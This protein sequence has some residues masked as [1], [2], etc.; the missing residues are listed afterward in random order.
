MFRIA[1]LLVKYDLISDI[2]GQGKLDN[3]DLYPQ[4]YHLK[5]I[6]TDHQKKTH[7]NTHK[8]NICM[9]YL[10]YAWFSRMKQNTWKIQTPFLIDNYCRKDSLHAYLHDLH[11][12]RFGF[13]FH[14]HRIGEETVQWNVEKNARITGT[15]PGPD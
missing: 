15:N 1:I 6:F 5:T 12:G 4:I 11:S 10:H 2:V 8:V 14:N 3:P 7:P 13:Y 9:F